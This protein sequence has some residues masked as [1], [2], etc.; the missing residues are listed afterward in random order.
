ME[1]AIELENL[2]KRF[3]E[4]VAV[5]DLS[6]RL[7]RGSFLGLLGRNGAGKSTTLKMITGL[8]IKRSY[9]SARDGPGNRRP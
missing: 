4:K 7:E 9:S 5:D 3:G 1:F 8:L 2:T 6:I